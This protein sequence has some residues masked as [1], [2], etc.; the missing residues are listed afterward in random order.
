MKMV[1]GE[2]TEKEK[3]FL[4]KKFLAH[5][6]KKNAERREENENVLGR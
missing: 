3:V 2:D 1:F 4:E 5:W 6:R